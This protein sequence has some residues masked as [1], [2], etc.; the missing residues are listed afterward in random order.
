MRE[1]HY[2]SAGVTDAVQKKSIRLLIAPMAALGET[3]GPM[4]RVKALASEALKRGHK[5]AFCAAE[6]GN[7]RPLEGV[8]NY[9]APLP[10]PFGTP[11][12]LGRRLLGIS[13]ALHVQQRKQIRSFE[14]VLHIVG[15]I[16]KRFFPR[17]VQLI[18]NAIRAFQPDI[19]F[20]ECRPAAIVAAR[21]EHVS[22]VTGYSFPIQKSYAA[23]P[24]YSQG[25]NSFLRANHLPPVE[26][27][28]D[29]VDWAQRKVVPS[30]PELEPLTDPSIVYVGP[31]QHMEPA[32]TSIPLADR[33]KILVYMGAASIS[34][35][36]LFPALEAA[37]AD[38]DYELYIG[39]QAA[40]PLHTERLHIDRWFDFN[41][42]LP[43]AL[44]YIN[45]GGQNSI[46]AG[47]VYGVPQII[48]PGPVFERQYN[49]A[50]IEK[51][52]AGIHLADADFTP[53]KLRRLIMEIKDHPSYAEH[54]RNAGAGLLKLGGAARVVDLLEEEVGK[55]SR[56]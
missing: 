17:D 8:D 36:R 39:T 54:A 37:F 56:Q 23:N 45:H 33:K 18:R 14:E 12:W 20:A 11:I 16:D 31:L 52:Q 35:K 38:T 30:S 46:I 7:Y 1:E 5:V 3:G 40:K 51:L 27:V 9:V 41:K 21:L 47:L 48:C 13:Q 4:S 28:L 44:A 22:V 34:P 26:S 42:L 15:A 55:V 6:D 10:S 49:A 50:S 43:D 53:E 24:E 32:N 25:V 19:V 29:L 2:S